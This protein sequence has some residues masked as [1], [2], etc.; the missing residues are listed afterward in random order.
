MAPDGTLSFVTQD[1]NNLKR[2]SIT[3]SPETSLETLL[4]MAR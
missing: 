2:V 1:D 4:T 3:P